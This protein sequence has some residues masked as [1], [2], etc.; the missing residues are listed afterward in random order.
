[1]I[2]ATEPRQ[3]DELLAHVL[4]DVCTDEP[5]LARIHYKLAHLQ[6]PCFGC[7]KV[8]S[9]LQDLQVRGGSQGQGVC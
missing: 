4:V 2:E 3:L 5:C 6:T 8:L 1:M 7:A 9:K